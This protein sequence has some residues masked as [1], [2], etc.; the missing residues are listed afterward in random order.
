MGKKSAGRGAIRRL[1]ASA[2]VAIALG[3]PAAGADG[4]AYVVKDVTTGTEPGASSDPGPFF[5]LGH[6]TVFFASDGIHGRELWRSDGTGA[7]T[8]LVKDVAP[9]PADG[10]AT[11]GHAADG[12]LYF[13]GAE[14]GLW[15]SD[16]TA[17]GTS[18]LADLT[19]WRIIADGNR[20][21][22]AVLVGYESVDLF[23]IDLPG[24]AT[25]LLGSFHGDQLEPSLTLVGGQLF[26]AADGGTEGLWT[27]DGTPEGTRLV[28]AA[29]LANSEGGNDNTE[30][31]AVG[32]LVFFVANDAAGW[33]LWR[34]DGTEGGTYRVRDINPGPRYGIHFNDYWEGA[35]PFFA[36]GIINGV[37]HAFG[38]RSYE[39][40]ST[41]TNIIP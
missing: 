32:G 27:S 19:P 28:R 39:M 29:Q 4:P 3:A 40:A 16:G 10:V 11:I 30:L 20:L 36:A 37:G 1:V 12:V 33:E 34:S 38:Y 18:R 21:Y 9:G 25:T 24:G 26:F 23:R 31:I 7:G 13:P 15:R 17:A 35:Q 14:G 41:A 2:A 5:D 6:T 8:V 22:V